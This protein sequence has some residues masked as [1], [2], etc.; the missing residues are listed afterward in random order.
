MPILRAQASLK[1]IISGV[2]LIFK[3][4]YSSLNIL[5]LA[6]RLI[7]REWTVSE[8]G[9]KASISSKVCFTSSRSSPG[10]PMIRSMLMLSN[11][12]ALAIWNFSFTFSTVWRR[13]IRSKVFWFMVWGLMEIRLM[14]W[15]AKTFNF[16]SVMLSGRPASTVNSRTFFVSNSCSNLHKI[17]S[18]SSAGS[19]VGVPPP[20]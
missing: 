10:S 4:A 3:S 5:S 20:K 15:E 14:P 7:A 11:P 17:A 16:S 8:S 6:A 13:P 1:A 18:M 2:L 19:E 9:F 12:S